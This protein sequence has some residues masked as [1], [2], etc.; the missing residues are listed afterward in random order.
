MLTLSHCS[1]QF[2]GNYLFDDITFTIGTRDRIGL[3]GK[4]GAGKSTMLKILS[5]NVASDEGNVIKSND[6]TIGF[7]TQDLQATLGKTVLEEAMT[8]FDV[9]LEIEK[10]IDH[11]NNELVIR[12]DYESDEYANILDRHAHLHERFN[13]L[14]GAS[15]EGTVQRILIGLGFEEKDL[16][17]LVDEFSGGWQMRV[18]LAKILLKN[19]DCLL[20]DEPTNHLDIES[21]QWLELFL[22]NYEGALVLISHDKAFLDIATNRTIEITNGGIEDY[23]CSYSKYLV[24][25]IQRRDLVKQAY[26]NQQKEIAKTEEFIERFRSKAN[27]A[28]RVQS[29]IKMLDKIDRIELEEEDNSAINFRFPTAPRSGLMVIES[30]DLQKSYGSKHVLKGIDFA[31]ERGRKMAFVGKNGEGKTTCAKILAGVEPY[32]GTVTIGHNVS[33]GYFAQQQA[34]TLDGNRT[35]FETVDDVATGEMR[36]KIRAL[37]GA[38]LF[39]GDDVYKKVKVLSGGEKSRL[40]MAILLLQPSNLLILDEPTNH[41]DM[42]SKD[43]LKKAIKNYEGSLIVVSHDREFLEGLTDQVAEFKIGKVRVYEGDIYEYLRQRN[44]EQ[45]AD[46]EIVKQQ[47]KVT[48]AP[49]VSHER[50]ELKK[51]DQE[52]RKK[53][54]RIQEL[55]YLINNWEVEQKN[56]EEQMSDPTLYSMPDL[57]KSIHQNYNVIKLSLEKALTEWTSLSD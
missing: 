6:Y 42:R 13:F 4:N 56:L 19:P 18:E 27:L 23:N 35:V 53:E 2:G 41:L 15:V 7:L 25:R 31:I 33:I 8:S 37:L 26:A 24:E 1:V 14:G 22:K 17:R 49:T 45:L 43:V 9:L 32:E 38:F 11:L 51:N 54:K 39:S 3:V 28:S 44:I 21:V 5:G 20:L 52:K 29:R 16:Y 36:T 57:M 10:E 47:K 30:T 46:L 12:T 34:E 55:E 48:K 50:E 40:A